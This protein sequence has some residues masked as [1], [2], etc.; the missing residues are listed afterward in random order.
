[1]D[2]V[3]IDPRRDCQIYTDI[4]ARQGTRITRIFE[5]HRNEDYVIGSLDLSRRTGAAI[6]LGD[7][8]LIDL[9]KGPK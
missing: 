4:A 2:A 7:K 1:T 3:V 6:F 8:T 9:I 5:T